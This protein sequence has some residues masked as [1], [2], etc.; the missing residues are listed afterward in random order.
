VGLTYDTPKLI[1]V[2]PHHVC[3]FLYVT[4]SRP[5]TGESGYFS[6]RCCGSGSALSLVGWSRIRIGNADPDP[7]VQN[8]IQKSEKSEEM[9]RFEVLDALF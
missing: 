3:V 4:G 1:S 5:I 8:D 2:S 6:D 9:F 7:G